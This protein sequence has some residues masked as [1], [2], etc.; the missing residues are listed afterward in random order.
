MLQK[1]KN[2]NKKLK[3]TFII[4]KFNSANSFRNS[5]FSFRILVNA[6]MFLREF[7]KSLIND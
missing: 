4:K 1:L 5:F 2:V 7:L 6:L 3:V